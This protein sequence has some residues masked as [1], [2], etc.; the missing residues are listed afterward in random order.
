MR[1]FK[2]WT[3]VNLWIQFHKETAG[4]FAMTA[5]I[6]GVIVIC[7]SLVL[8]KPGEHD[9]PVNGIVTQLIPAQG[10]NQ[11]KLVVATEDRHGAVI[12]PANPLSCR[13]GSKIVVA[14]RRTWWGSLY[15]AGYGPGCTP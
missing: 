4:F 5:A 2:R 1:S 8:P 7:A 6:L 15:S 10:K 12:T 11:L 3:E 9:L 14:K 13:I